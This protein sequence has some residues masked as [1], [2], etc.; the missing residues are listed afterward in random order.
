M[1]PTIGA[2]LCCT[3]NAGELSAES[4]SGYIDNLIGSRDQEV[5]ASGRSR[6]IKIITSLGSKCTA[7]NSSRSYPSEGKTGFVVICAEGA[8][9]IYWSDGRIVLHKK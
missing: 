8:Y 1:V 5:S 2:L 7:I 6:I 4:V 9:A 3:V